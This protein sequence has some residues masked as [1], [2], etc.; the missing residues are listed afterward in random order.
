MENIPY[1][2][3]T[4]ADVVVKHIPHEYSTEMATKSEIVCN[5]IV[6]EKLINYVI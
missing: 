6:C 2:K 3:T 4:F 5:S 1:F